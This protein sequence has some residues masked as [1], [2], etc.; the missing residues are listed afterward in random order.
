[1]RIRKSSINNPSVN[2]PSVNNGSYKVYYIILSIIVFLIILMEMDRR[3]S[4]EYSITNYYYHLFPLCFIGLYNTLIRT[5]NPDHTHTFN[6]NNFKSHSI[7]KESWKD[8]QKEA[9]KLYNDKDGL[10]NMRSLV[11]GPFDVID[12]GDNKWK[13]CVLKWYDKPIQSNIMKFPKTIEVI[14]KCDDIQ[15]AM[16]SILEPGKYIPPHKGPFTACLRYHFGLKIPND[17][18]NCYI[19]VNNEKF[20]W[21]EGDALIFDDTY[22][23][24]VYNNTSEPR[25][26][27]FIDI[28][29]P[30]HKNL[31]NLTTNILKYSSLN[32]MVKEI[33]D[34]SEKT[35]EAFTNKEYFIHF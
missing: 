8:I 6:P 14:N 11:K 34:N 7:I 19:K 24:E 26:I 32:K 16:I 35:H 15:A 18:D 10:L 30:L 29:R 27:L 9:L 23:H 22:I 2:K 28:R 4:Y 3:F 1:M 5:C 13:V 20:N 31:Y 17:K 21:E 12:P 25:I 33:N